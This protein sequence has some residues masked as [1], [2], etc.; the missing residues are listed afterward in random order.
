MDE[1][2]RVKESSQ[3]GHLI[4]S[5]RNKRGLRPQKGEQ[6]MNCPNCERVV[7]GF[8]LRCRVCHQRLFFWYVFAIILALAALTGLFF[9][10]ELV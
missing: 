6:K 5:R 4:G 2:D 3:R 8:A 10:L 9:L 1:S 7:G